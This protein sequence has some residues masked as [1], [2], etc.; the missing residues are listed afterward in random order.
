VDTLI[1]PD[2]LAGGDGRSPEQATCIAATMTIPHADPIA[3]FV[4]CNYLVWSRRRS[5]VTA[6]LGPGLAGSDGYVKTVGQ[7][8]PS[9]GASRGGATAIW[10]SSNAPARPCPGMSAGGSRLR[11]R[12]SIFR[13]YPDAAAASS[14]HF[15]GRPSWHAPTRMTRGLRITRTELRQGI[16][17]D[18]FQANVSAA[19][20]V[21]AIRH[22]RSRLRGT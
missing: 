4:T 18:R 12:K 7:S 1:A 6:A 8:P 22:A 15:K 11:R 5:V 13:S 16:A 19:P 14:R 10:T 2:L 9:G 17:A 3:E 20:Q 21:A